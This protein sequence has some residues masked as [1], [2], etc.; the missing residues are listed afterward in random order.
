MNIE[1]HSFLEVAQELYI[2]FN[3][4]STFDQAEPNEPVIENPSS[5]DLKLH[6][7]P[8][9]LP[10]DF[11][12]IHLITSDVKALITEID[13]LS[14]RRSIRLTTLP[15][16]VI[17]KLLSSGVHEVVESGFELALYRHI[18][19][20]TTETEDHLINT[21]CSVFVAERPTVGE[22]RK[23]PALS[24]RPFHARA[25]GPWVVVEV[26]Y[27]QTL[28]SLKRDASWWAVHNVYT[29]VFP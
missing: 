20:Q 16:K 23:E 28:A 13:R 9:V 19:A 14:F 25:E 12:I 17:A 24:Y 22:I 5:S 26:G 7:E 29:S 15:R 8:L 11:K 27:S 21:G 1:S 3:P 2:G 6:L 18:A 4:Q 10:N